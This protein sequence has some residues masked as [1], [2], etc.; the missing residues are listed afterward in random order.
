MLTKISEEERHRL[1][2]LDVEAGAI[3]ARAWRK[4]NAYTDELAAKYGFDP[5]KY[6]INRKT[7]EIILI[8]DLMT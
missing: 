8:T 1:V 6:G 7:G 2:E 3:A 5:K 4:V